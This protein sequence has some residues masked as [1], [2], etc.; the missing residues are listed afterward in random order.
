MRSVRLTIPSPVRTQSPQLRTP[1]EAVN[2]RSKAKRKTLVTAT[3]IAAP[4]T[5]HGR[6][7][8]AAYC[9]ANT[10]FM[11]LLCPAEGGTVG[12]AEGEEDGADDSQCGSQGDRESAQAGGAD[13]PAHERTEEEPAI[14]ADAVER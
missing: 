11:R 8:S 9:V 12:A 14:H 10:L 2:G 1:S 4:H 6:A 5:G 13:E 3:R 7:N